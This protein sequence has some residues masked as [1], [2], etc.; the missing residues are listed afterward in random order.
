MIRP[1]FSKY[2]VIMVSGDGVA[3]KKVPR[4]PKY[5]RREVTEVMHFSILG[6]K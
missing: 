3:R 4:L 1:T 6:G 2:T 5:S